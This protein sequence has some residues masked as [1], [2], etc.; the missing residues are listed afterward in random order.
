MHLMTPK[1]TYNLERDVFVCDQKRR[2]SAG[3]W[4]KKYFEIVKEFRWSLLHSLNCD[5]P[6][7]TGYVEGQFLTMLWPDVGF[8]SVNHLW[9]L[10]TNLSFKEYSSGYQNSGVSPRRDNLV[11]L[12]NHLR[13][14]RLVL[15]RAFRL[16]VLVLTAERRAL[17]EHLALFILSC[18]EAKTVWTPSY[19]ISFT[20]F[21]D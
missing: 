13:D 21:T 2:L 6:G 18:Y 11:A 8:E 17:P 10:W 16:G 15:P 19:L 1:G 20:D 14:V 5:S 3:L 12:I 4:V 9:I 7:W